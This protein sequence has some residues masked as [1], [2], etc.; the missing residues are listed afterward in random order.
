L[1]HSVLEEYTSSDVV[2]A[3]ADGPE[4]VVPT[5]VGHS[6]GEVRWG[7]TWEHPVAH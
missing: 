6:Q 1:P 3:S 7:N 5:V 2:G 4:R